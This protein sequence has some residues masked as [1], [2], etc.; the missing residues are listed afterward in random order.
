MMTNRR[1]LSGGVAAAAL[2]LLLLSACS[3]LDPGQLL[4]PAT[5]SL[6][7]PTAP[8]EA[9]LPAAPP[10]TDQ[11]PGGETPVL[12]C[13]PPACAPGEVY[14]CGNS[15]GCPGGCGTVCAAPT[16]APGRPATGPLAPAPTD[17]EGLE[18][19]LTD[20]W[21][22]NVNPAAVRA[23]LQQSG[24]QR[25]D[26]DWRAADL[27]GDL[28]DEWIAV[29]YDPSLPTAP[30]GAPGDLW[31]V[32]GDGVVF[33][34]YV[35]PSSDIYSFLAP[36]IIA[37]ADVTGDRRPEIVANAPFCGAH[38]CTS[39]YRVIGQ[40]AAGLADLV[41]RAPLADDDPGTTIAMPTADIQVADTNSDG[42]ADLVVHGGA[43]GS[44]GAGTV[45]TRSEVWRWDGAAV[46]LA[47]TRLD[48][49]N[50]RHL[51]L[52]EANDRLAAGDLDGALTL[53]EAVINDPA[54]VTD[55]FAHAPEQVTADI[56]RF[57]AFRL[58]LIDL[59]QGDSTRA[60]GRLEWL[61]ANHPDAPAT[62]AA[63]LLLGGWTGAE[64]QAALCATIESEMAALDSPTGTLSDMGYGNPSLGAAD[65]CP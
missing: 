35:A 4:S 34:Y 25:S 49:T 57:A 39:N 22:G 52:Y 12:M 38:T 61:Q 48:P 28:L 17:W 30:F 62:T 8:P 45:R 14:A 18:T 40:T 36:T 41:Q 51:L 50:L 42:A 33:R 63:A 56:Q 32:N 65:F 3:V 13:T 16:A 21:R 54:V 37:I 9:T 1:P 20:L 44:A 5:P 27:N 53:Y 19:W 15:D 26:A 6:T 64:G 31:V 24:V 7:G 43:I 55:S 46:T 29:L 60:A 11:L 59:L 58:I 2:A 10:T 47:E 23:A